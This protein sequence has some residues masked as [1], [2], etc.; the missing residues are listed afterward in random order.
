MNKKAINVLIGA[1]A[2]VNMVLSFGLG[3]LYST[4]GWFS[5]LIYAIIYYRLK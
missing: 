4:I 3:N 1:V 5:T 2:M